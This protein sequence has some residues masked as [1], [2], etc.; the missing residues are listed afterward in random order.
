MTTRIHAHIHVHTQVAKEFVS[1]LREA[2]EIAHKSRAA[3]WRYGDC[4]SDDE[5]NF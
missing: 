2:Q 1:R 3:M 5:D 4:Q